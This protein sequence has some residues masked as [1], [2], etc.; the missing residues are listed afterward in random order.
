MYERRLG[1]G[2]AVVGQ[3]VEP[4]MIYSNTLSSIATVRQRNPE[5]RRRSVSLDAPL[6]V[7]RLLL[8]RD[9]GDETV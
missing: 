7:R 5:T 2:E 4:R 8:R 9:R 3:S 6:S 1:S